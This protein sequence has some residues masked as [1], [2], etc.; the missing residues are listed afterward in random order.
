MFYIEN[1]DFLGPIYRQNPT[2]LSFLHSHILCDNPMCFLTKKKCNY[3]IDSRALSAN[4]IN[5]MSL[6]L[7]KIYMHCSSII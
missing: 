3:L 6:F 4:A 5:N 1:K 2:F 7:P